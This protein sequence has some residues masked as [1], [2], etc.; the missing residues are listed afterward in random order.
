M[1]I[2]VEDPAVRRAQIQLRNSNAAERRRERAKR[3]NHDSPLALAFGLK[4]SLTTL[5]KLVGL[6]RSN[7]MVKSR[8]A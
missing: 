1:V 7:P 8:L 6:L 4:N 3:A 5:L 2:A